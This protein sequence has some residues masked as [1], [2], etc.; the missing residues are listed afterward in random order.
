VEKYLR[1]ENA[2]VWLPFWLSFLSGLDEA[3]R[4]RRNLVLIQAFVDDSGV[5]GQG[6][7]FVFS[8]LLSSALMWARFSDK[9]KACIEET[10]SILYFKMHEAVKRCGEFAKFSPTER[11]EKLKRLCAI[12]AGASLMEISCIVKLDDFNE[13]LGK[14]SAG[15]MTHPYFYPFYVTVLGVAHQLLEW[16]HKEPFEI[17]FDEHVIF[18]PRVKAW[19]P[20]IRTLQDADVRSIMPVEPFFRS[21]NDILPL[22]AADLTAW[23]HRRVNNEGLGE[24]AWVESALTGLYPSEFSNRFTLER[25]KGIVDKSYEITPEKLFQE[26]REAIE[27]YKQTFDDEWPPQKRKK[28][29]RRK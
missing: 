27:V 14:H 24:F 11:D 2:S 15:P 23:M 1:V 12:I 22:Q 19:Y 13:T 10:P 3:R 9:W 6:T 17:I 4:K 21:D 8:A 7:V 28:P 5:K 20:V 26:Q 16:G 25:M 18:G 29:S